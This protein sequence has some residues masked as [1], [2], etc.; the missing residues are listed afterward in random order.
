MTD[1]LCLYKAAIDAGSPV[2]ARLAAKYC[3]RLGLAMP[4]WLE[5]ALTRTPAKGERGRGNSPAGRLK[6]ALTDYEVGD[7]A[8]DLLERF[9]KDAGGPV[10]YENVHRV[11]AYYKICDNLGLPFS[12]EDALLEE[13]VPGASGVRRALERWRK[14]IKAGDGVALC[15]DAGRI[16]LKKSR[17]PDT[18][19]PA[20]R[21]ENAATRK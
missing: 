19:R 15:Y 2:H 16:R 9:G 7:A 11:I 6:K 20:H 8:E 5:D 13:D 21:K 10:R 1:A 4:E 12:I 18:P 3:E 17:L 14:R